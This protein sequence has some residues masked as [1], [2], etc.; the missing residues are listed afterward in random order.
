MANFKY[1]AI[2]TSGET[3][4]GVIEATDQMAAV[5]IIKE[6]CSIIVEIKE[7]DGPEIGY[8]PR[9]KKCDAKLLSLMC[10]RFA[11]ILGV[12]LPIV[13]AVDLLTGQ[14]EDKALKGILQKVSKDVAMGRTLSSSFSAQDGFF[15]V[16]FI[17]SVRSGEESGNLAETFR[18]LAGYYERINKTKQK[19]ISSLTYPALTMCVGAIVMVVIM[20]VAVPM[21]T[22]SFAKMGAELPAITQ[23]VINTSNFFINYG[24]FVLFALAAIILGC[25]L[26]QRTEAG[27][28]FFS[29]ALL[30]IPIVGTIIQMS[31]ASQFAHTM[32][33]MLT[34]GMPII[35]S[36]ETAGK[37]IGNYVMRR[38]IM[39]AVSGVESGKSLFA[40]LEKSKYLPSMLIEMIAV[41][42]T[43]GT[44]ETTLA[45]IAGYYD[46]EVDIHTSR[47]TAVLEPA[48]ICVLAVFVVVILFSVY[49][50]IFS[51][52]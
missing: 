35:N 32:S 4:N 26:Y 52:Y 14:M 50:P 1:K 23:F 41:G 51:M 47:A 16:T 39:A 37:S 30:M 45:A 2:S 3:V 33:M 5:A 9:T 15:P 19:V 17:E 36:I 28:E 10:D 11:I 31:G 24:V 49:L 12:G 43:T 8:K 38:D 22:D 7:V 27:A 18:H 29:S 6:T 13:K 25:K 40:C 42:E 46:N 21:F 44:L 48:I 20:V 34:S